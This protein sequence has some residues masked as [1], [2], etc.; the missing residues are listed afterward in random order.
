MKF[1]KYDQSQTHFVVLDYRAILG[2]GS[3]A[4]L[5]N[6]IVEL[7]DL[8]AIEEKYP[9]VGNLGYHP[10]AM[11]KILFWG[12][13]KNFRCGRPLHR[14]YNTDLALRYYSNDDFP[15]HRTINNFRVKFKS[16]LVATFSQIVMLCDELDLIGY[17]NL[18]IDSHKLKANANLFQNKNLKGIKKALKTIEA[19]FVTLLEKEVKFPESNEEITKKREKLHRR[20]TKL[21]EAA[22]LLKAAGGEEDKTVRHNLTDPD[23][24]IMKDKR[25]VSNPD[26]NCHNGVDDK[27]GVITAV[28]VTNDANDNKDLLPMKEKSEEHTGRS[29]NHVSADCGYI[30]KELYDTMDADTETDYY[31]P[32]RSK[33]SS[34]KDPYSKWK[35]LHIPERDVYL[36][37]E[38]KELH[39][40]RA[41]TSS[42]GH[43]FRLYQ[44]ISCQECPVRK[45]CLKPKRKRSKK[46]KKKAAKKPRPTYRT[47]TIYPEDPQVK[48]MREK[49]DSEDGKAIYQRRMATAEP[50]NGDMQ[51]NRDFAQ[52]T[53]RG[54]PKVNLEYTLLAAAQ[55]I[56]KI[57]LHRADAFMKLR[58]TRAPLETF[59]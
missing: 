40:Q 27:Y 56:R 49:L 58:K 48:A 8:S 11:V 13:L 44:G 37:P 33:H 46:A 22:E 10:R 55:N 20:K 1:R 28:L 54:L 45:A 41:G 14:Q 9:E 12:Y 6:D 35:F 39:F 43:D 18:C 25:G 3:E 34:K 42:N 23:S 2:E 32:D 4:V 59:C 51:K 17:E 57:I 15:D 29:H 7:L 31:I 53:V 26:Y 30:S 38:G 24:R 47:I 36:C 52:F 19:Q 16:E 50:A 5:V 21:E